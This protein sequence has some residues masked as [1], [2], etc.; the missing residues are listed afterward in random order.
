MTSEEQEE[1]ADTQET[2]HPRL[3]KQRILRQPKSTRTCIG[4]GGP[5]DM[6]ASLG[7]SCF[8]CYDDLSG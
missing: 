7:P 3:P 6:N 2:V 1:Q 5:G 4:C 8:D